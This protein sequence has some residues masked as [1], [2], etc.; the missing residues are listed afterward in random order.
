[1]MR[2]IFI[3]LLLLLCAT[4]AQ[5]IY[6]G[7]SHLLFSVEN[8]KGVTFQIEVLLSLS[9]NVDLFSLNFAIL[10]NPRPPYIC[11]LLRSLGTSLKFPSHS[12]MYDV[13]YGENIRK[14]EN[15]YLVRQK[16]DNDGKGGNNKT[17][18]KMYQT[19][20]K[21]KKKETHTDTTGLTQT[22]LNHPI[23]LKKQTHRSTVYFA[24]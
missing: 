9:D 15:S 18:V 13:F 11:T 20:G 23:L 16:P 10:V 14:V 24:R 22:E 6:E 21:E 3:S 5:A 17:Q 1:M 2:D 12:M 4:K 19:T 7:K 8:R